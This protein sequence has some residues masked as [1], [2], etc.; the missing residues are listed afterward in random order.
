MDAAAITIAHAIPGRVRLKV[1]HVRDD[2]AFASEL[3]QKLAAMLG[4]REVEVRPR[5]GSVVILYDV[6]VLG[7]GD[8]LQSLAE[9]LTPLFP[10]LTAEDLNAFA[11]LAATGAAA[12][13]M[14]SVGESVRAFFASIN[15]NI[16]RATGGSADL[17]ILLPLTLFAIGVRSLLKSDKLVSP[18]WYDFLWFALGTY[19]MLNPKPNENRR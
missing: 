1:A 12:T 3:R 4:V 7:T 14:P 10:G 17:K 6:A 13:E 19:F 2:A 15:D 16:R 9:S 18:T 11:T 8:S 5:T